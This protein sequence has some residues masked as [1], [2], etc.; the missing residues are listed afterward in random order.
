MVSRHDVAF[1]QVWYTLLSGKC[2]EAVR[3]PM[4]P[5]IPEKG[6]QHAPE[7]ALRRQLVVDVGAN[8]GYYSLYAAAHGCRSA[9]ALIALLTLYRMHMPGTPTM[10]AEGT[11]QPYPCC[12]RVVAWEPV[13]QFRAFLEYG[14]QLNNFHMRVA[15]RG[16]AV[17]DVGGAQLRMEVPRRG[18]WGTA[19]VGGGNIDRCT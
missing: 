3:E 18:I 15:A 19:S 5:G 1:V 8:F 10:H 6:R 11:Q 14:L 7:Q 16:V 9:V 13:P 4:L 12:C 17:S 2:V